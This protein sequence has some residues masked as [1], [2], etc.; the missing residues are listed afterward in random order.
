M[1]KYI[2]KDKFV[3][4]D[5]LG[6]FEVVGIYPVGSSG[7]AQTRY[8]IQGKGKLALDESELDDLFK[9]FKPKKEKGVAK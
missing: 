6:I 3:L 2:T 4:R 8:I 1:A 5:D 9:E 7:Q